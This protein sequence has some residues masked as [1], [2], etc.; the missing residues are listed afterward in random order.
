VDPSSPNL[1]SDGQWATPSRPIPAPVSGGEILVDD[2]ENT[3]SSFDK[4]AGTNFTGVCDGNCNGWASISGGLGNRMFD[5]ASDGGVQVTQWARWKPLIPADGGI[6]EVYVHVPDTTGASWQAPYVIKHFNGTSAGMVDQEELN[7]QWASIGIY[8]MSSTDYVWTHDA[9]QEATNQHCP[10][11][12]CRLRVDAVKFVRRGVIYLPDYQYNNGGTSS[13]LHLRNNGGGPAEA[14][15]K[16][17]KGDR[18]VACVGSA[19]MNAHHTLSVSC[20]DPNVASAVVDSSQD[21]SAVVEQVGTSQISAYSGVQAD[22]LGDAQWATTGANLALPYVYRAYS[23]YTSSIRLLN[24][25]A[26]AA[27]VYLLYYDRNGNYVNLASG[28]L[29]PYTTWSVQPNTGSGFYGSVA[30]QSNQPLAVLSDAYNTAIDISTQAG[31]GATSAYLPYIMRNYGGW[32]SCFVVRNLSVSA[33]SVTIT[34][35]HSGGTT[36]ESQSI[37]GNGMWTRCQQSIGGMPDGPLA[38]W[39]TSNSGLSFVLAINQSQVSAGKH[40]SYNGSQQA[41]RVVSLP[42]LRRNH[43]ENG[44]TWSSGFQVQNAGDGYTCFTVSYFTPAGASIAGQSSGCLNPGYAQ[45]FYLPNVTVTG[46]TDGLWSALV[47]AEQPLVVVANATCTS[48]GGDNVY[49][50]N[51]FA[52]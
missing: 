20:P 50:Y 6:Y 27:N 15:I 44:R 38:A 30:I 22:P 47:T 8:R 21:L 45:G 4:G 3:S 41:S 37:A 48:C 31:V 14:L 28:A 10:G 46:M 36:V 34:Y 26:Q 40:M 42:L 29:S 19:M 13:T 23:G 33:N 39:I 51:G 32:N 43:S 7:N 9:S 11:A 49:A 16:Y 17:Y 5:T 18:T 24:T 1:W 2:T 35:Y 52:R 12:Y 25:N